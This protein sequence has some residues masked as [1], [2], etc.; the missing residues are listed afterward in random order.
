MQI[1]IRDRRWKHALS[2]QRGLESPSW[3]SLAGFFFVWQLIAILAI[4]STFSSEQNILLI[5]V[6]V[7][8]TC[9]FWLFCRQPQNFNRQSE[10]FIA[11]AM[12]LAQKNPGLWGRKQIWTWVKLRSMRRL[13]YL[14]CVMD[15]KLLRFVEGTWRSSKFFI[16]ATR[17]FS[18]WIV[19]VT[20]RFIVQECLRLPKFS[21]NMG[22]V[23]HMPR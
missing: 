19:F 10:N 9:W 17:E 22:L 3:A 23:G 1:R 11:M 2:V 14:S 15:C 7:Q 5:L 20:K 8:D 4:F 18:Y 6:P 16:A 13:Y 21:R 12:E